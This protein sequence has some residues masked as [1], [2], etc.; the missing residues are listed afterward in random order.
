MITRAQANGAVQLLAQTYN[1]WARVDAMRAKLSLQR[2]AQIPRSRLGTVRDLIDRL[3]RSGAIVRLRGGGLSDLGW[4]AVAVVGL[5]ALGLAAGAASVV[6]ISIAWPAIKH[7]GRLAKEA[8]TKATQLL[9]LE[10]Y[11]QRMVD[12]V[13]ANRARE[14]ASQKAGD[15]APFFAPPEEAEQDPGDDPA[16]EQ[17][18]AAARI[19][20][21]L[22]GPASR[23]TIPIL[24]GSIVLALLLAS[25][26][27]RR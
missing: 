9:S 19:T 22:T 2:R 1:R 23:Y 17:P 8:E 11:E 4:V 18:T 14:L 6:A 3:V 26:R 12:T 5:A 27:G 16:I 10:R 25:T 7:E 21:W 24:G 15:I 13:G 20:Q